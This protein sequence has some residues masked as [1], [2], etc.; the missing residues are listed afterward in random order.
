[1]V[2]TIQTKRA[3]QHDHW[4]GDSQHDVIN[5][6]SIDAN[7]FKGGN[8]AFHF[9]HGHAFHN[10]AGELRFA[11]DHLQGDITG[12]GNPEFDFTVPHAIW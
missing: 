8:Q 11:A 12:D 10:V 3:H 6:G 4:Y 1:M 9:I 2:P 7:P 5:L